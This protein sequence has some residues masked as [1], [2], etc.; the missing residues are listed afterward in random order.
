MRSSA[1]PSPR[2]IQRQ[3]FAS[4]FAV[5][6]VVDTAKRAELKNNF[7]SGLDQLG[8]LALLPGANL[9]EI[10]AKGRAVAVSG[11][12][13]GIPDIDTKMQTW[14][15]GLRYKLAQND[16]ITV[17]RDPAGLERFQQ[18][19][20]NGDLAGS[21]DPDKKVALVKEAETYR[22]QSENAAR[23]ASDKADK[24]AE[25][26]VSNATKQIEMGVPLTADGWTSLRSTVEGTP[27]AEDFNRL[28]TQERETQQVLRMPM[29]EQER[30]I[31]GRE[32]QL[33]QGGTLADRANLQRIKTTVEKNQKQL[34]DEPLVAAQRLYGRA[35]QPLDLND[36]LA[37]G[38]AE[39]AASLFAE[40]TA[41]LSAMREQFGGRIGAKPLLPQEAGLL[42]KA[43]DKAGPADANQLFGTLRGAIGDDETY[44]AVLQQIAPDSPV[45][46]RAGMLT[47]IDRPV[48][49][50]SNL[51]ASDV[52][53]SSAKVA[54]TMLTGESILNKTKAQKDQD[55]QARSL[56]VPARQDFA[57]SFADSVGNLYRSRPGAQEGDLQ[58]AFAYYVGKSAELGR[59]ASTPKDIDSKLVKEAIVATIGDVVD[60]N[61][62]G[63]AKAPIGMSGSEMQAKL[64]E[65][66]AEV[67][68]DQGLPPSAVASF[69]HYGVT[70]YRRD[71]QYLLTTGGV[72]VLGRNGAPLTIDLDPPPL[73]GTRYR[74][75]PAIPTESGP[76]GQVY[77]VKG[78]A[79]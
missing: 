1:R 36:L 66:F 38:G 27:F 40:R 22:W 74:R 68:K 47:A 48:T 44:R 34:E 78:A 60:V 23:V 28:V 59:L 67:V 10:L 42:V 73:S 5:D 14:E 8:K 26:A 12:T 29:A 54:E 19:L 9:D 51:I 31:Q 57:T 17:R 37:P 35:T 25:R 63:K 21:L 13:A 20:T 32:Q 2:G 6:Q 3:R 33:A 43:L 15:D 24:L 4:E 75:G 62:Q 79:R 55:G 46:A 56:F 50:Q 70:N 53:V 61:G 49:I 45:K 69:E 76:Q 72:P 39:R 11:R 65:R 41:T 58:A 7:S 71:G 18:R 30:Y 77:G 52:R 16:L 64:R